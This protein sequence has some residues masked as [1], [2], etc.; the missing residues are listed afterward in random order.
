M[1]RLCIALSVLCL[2]WAGPARGLEHVSLRHE[3]KQVRV[4]GRLI[5]EARDGGVLV[6]ARDGVIW[7]VEPKD[8]IGRTR[9]ETPF[10][11]LSADELSKQLFS[12]LP[13]G[14]SVHRTPHYLILYST[15]KEYA[16]WCASLF[17]RLYAAF[18][19]FWTRRGFK[20]S[21]PEFPLVAIIFAD[22]QSYVEHARKEVGESAKSMIGYFSLQTNRMTLGDLTGAA[23]LG[24]RKRG[25]ASAQVARIL[26][27]PEA[28]RMVATIVHEATHQ[29]AF[30]CGLHTRFSDC[31]LWFSEGIA[32]YFETP[33]VKNVKGWGTVGLVNRPR[34]A[35]FRDYLARRPA[36]SLATLL[37]DDKRFRNTQTGLDAYS[38]AWALT[39]YLM[40]RRPKEYVAYLRTLSAKK[41]LVWDDA[42]TRLREFTQAFGDD[43]QKLDADFT[44]YILRLK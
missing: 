16:Q 3:G 40:R 25:S 28:E 2:I 44:Q 15:S 26:A 37:T 43:L 20:L 1:V 18:V 29:I 17:E 22:Q 42:A 27:Q 7:A 30:N 34:L 21:E 33:D 32:I 13:Q 39:Y 31:P 4:E 35:Q 12:E 10:E 14:F 23:W 19:N 9:D 11:P 38:E 8:V 5:V 36:D 6:L 24:G 41:P